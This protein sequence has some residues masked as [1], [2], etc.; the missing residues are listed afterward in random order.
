[1]VKEETNTIQWDEESI[2]DARDI[3]EEFYCGVPDPYETTTQ[4]MEDA[5]SGRVTRVKDLDALF[6]DLQGDT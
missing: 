6:Q 4:A 5:R 3:D 2:Q 1:M